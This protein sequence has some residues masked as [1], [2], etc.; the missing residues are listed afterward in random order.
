M[1]LEEIVRSRLGEEA[2][3]ALARI[4]AWSTSPAFSAWHPLMEA[5]VQPPYVDELVDAFSRVLPFGTG[6][7]RGPVGVGT[8][9]FNPFTL[10][11]GVQGHCA[12]LR[13]RFEGSIQVVITYDV[14]AFHDVAG[15]YPPG[16]PSTLDGMTS[17]TLAELAARIY[18]ANGIRAWIQ[19][20][21]DDT[22]FS[23]PE[24]SFLIRELGAQGGLNV[25]ASHNP[26]DDNGSKFYDQHGG[27]LVPPHDQELLDQVVGLESYRCVSWEEAVSH[28]DFLGEEHHRA[29]VEAVVAG[30]PAVEPFPVAVT[31]L[32]GAGRVHE[33]LEEAGF[34]TTIIAEQARPDGRFPTVPGQ[35]ANPERPEVFDFALEA[36]E[37]EDVQL[38][39]ATDPDADRIGCMVRHEDSWVFLTGNQ[40]AALVIDARLRRWKGPG[41]PLVLH[42][43]VSST[44]LSRVA[45]SHG[46]EVRGDLLVG[47]KYIADVMNGVEEGRFAVGAEESHGLLVSD[48]MRDKDAAGGA[49]WLAIAAADAAEDL[50]TLVDKLLTFDVDLGPVRN[51]QITERFEGVEGRARMATF[52][53]RLRASPPSHLAGRE[54]LSFVDHR[55]PS[56]I[57]GPIRSSTD[58]AARNVL[59]L[60]LE[61]GGRVIFRPS[62]TEPKL[63]VYLEVAGEPGQTGVEKELERLAEAVRALLAS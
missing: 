2:N 39:F 29:Y 58:A 60:C 33:V 15:R 31:S 61:G 45:A 50:L 10:G 17:R 51:M 37:G 49:L 28:L 21:G 1:T 20:R 63:K 26:P 62:G 25:S 57:H 52:L 18:A 8:N 4:A 32:H 35:V 5:M 46:A 34:P 43:E 36:L 12:Y 40:I 42:T 23:T 13:A 3:A 47:F 6:G 55:D 9:R 19:P 38:L 44:L 41:Q 14:R 22:F 11:T 59:A 24:L 53:E 27:Q 30:A 16:V 48:R 7:R 56:G 54:V